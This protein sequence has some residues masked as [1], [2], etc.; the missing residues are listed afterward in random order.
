MRVAEVQGGHASLFGPV[1]GGRFRQIELCVRGETNLS[2]WTNVR[3]NP[4]TSADPARV[5][6]YELVGNP[7][8]PPPPGNAVSQV[9]Q[10][11]TAM[12]VALA[13]NSLQQVTILAASNS[14]TF[15]VESG[16]MI[17]ADQENALV[18]TLIPPP[19]P[20]P[21]PPTKPAPF[22]GTGGGLH[23]GMGLPAAPAGYT[24]SL[25]RGSYSAVR[26]G[27]QV[28]LHATGT[29]NNLN[30]FADLRVHTRAWPPRFALWTYTPEIT[31]PTLRHFNFSQVFFFPPDVDTL[32]VYDADGTHEVKIITP[33]LA[34]PAAKALKTTQRG[35]SAGLSN[36]ET[37]HGKSLEEAVE[38]AIAAFPERFEPDRLYRFDVVGQGKLIGGFAGMNLWFANVARTLL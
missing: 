22:P 12:L 14:M 16:P 38:S 23:D 35:E 13:P 32:T 19:W 18:E 10:T 30:Q 7:P 27:S 11:V 5:A 2:G 20:T 31:L 4:M 37:G 8:P 28:I 26:L 6:V 9:A 33:D 34:A 17:A 24:E 36:I 25:G 29:L 3:L 1:V 15:A 21:F